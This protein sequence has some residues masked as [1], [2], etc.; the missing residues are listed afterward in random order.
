M[1]PVHSLVHIVDH[2]NCNREIENN[3]RICSKFVILKVDKILGDVMARI[4]VTVSYA[5]SK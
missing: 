1:L 4:N 3:L 2:L 5:R